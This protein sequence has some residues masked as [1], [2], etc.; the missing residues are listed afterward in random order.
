MPEGG[1]VMNAVTFQKEGHKY[2]DA[3]GR[4]VPSVSK[5]LQHFGYSDI[6]SVRKFIGDAAVDASSEFGSVVHDTCA[7]YDKDDLAGCDP[8]VELYL[9]GWKKYRM[10][11]KPTFIAIEQPLVSKIWGFAGQ[12]D[13]VEDKANFLAI[14]DI[15]TGVVTI[16]EK[17][18]TALY[19][20][21][22]EENY[23]Q[24]VIARMSVHLSENNYSIVPHKDKNDINIAKCLLTIYNDKRSKGLL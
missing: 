10:V 20:I 17:I 18:Q 24:K 14:P 23:G 9:N 13:R 21:L 1:Q 19:Q 22:V 12:P 3:A 2:F 11:Y 4:E 8:L 15:K 7:L 6:E 5:I 16:A